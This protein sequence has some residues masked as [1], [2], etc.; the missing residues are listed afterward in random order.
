MGGKAAGEEKMWKECTAP[1]NSEFES[2]NYHQNKTQLMKESGIVPAMPKLAALYFAQA[3]YNSIK[4]ND[5]FAAFS[6]RSSRHFQN[7]LTVYI[8]YY[9]IY[10]V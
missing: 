7:P 8:E 1:G 2:L 10:R 6:G 4:G 9:R 5:C 3:Q